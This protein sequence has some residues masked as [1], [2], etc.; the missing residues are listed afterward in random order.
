MADIDRMAD[1]IRNLPPE[2]IGEWMRMK[3]CPPEDWIAVLPKS[4]QTDGVGPMF[5]PSYVRFSSVITSPVFLRRAFLN[6]P[7]EPKP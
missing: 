5:W 2:P 4:V 3:G 1:L 6:E 7:Q